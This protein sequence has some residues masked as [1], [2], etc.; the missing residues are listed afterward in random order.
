MRAHATIKQHVLT[1][2]MPSEAQSVCKNEHPACHY[3]HARYHVSVFSHSILPVDW[4]ITKD[5]PW[6]V[7]LTNTFTATHI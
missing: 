1:I 2:S 4:W 5:N 3:E 7:T 6:L